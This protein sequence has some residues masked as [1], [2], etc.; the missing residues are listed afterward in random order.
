MTPRTPGHARWILPLLLTFFLLA[1]GAFRASLPFQIATW[2][3][4][5]L[6]AA[7]VVSV[8]KR[9]R[10][11][12]RHRQELAAAEAAR[13]EHA[14]RVAA[15]LRR[16]LPD[17]APRNTVQVWDLVPHADEV[18]ITDAPVH[19][20][21]YYGQTVNYTTSSGAFFG[22][23]MFVAAG[24]VGTA[25]GNASARSRAEAMAREQWREHRTVRLVVTNQRLCCMVGQTWLSFY[26]STITA[27]YPSAGHRS[28]V[29]T[30]GD[31]QPLL[32]AGPWAPAAAVVATLMTLGTDALVNHPG[33]RPLNGAPGLEPKPRDTHRLPPSDT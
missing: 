24:L 7:G 18:F 23:P 20:A 22:S 8:V 4:A 33:L 3:A 27:V 14:W 5:A 11:V 10:L 15:Q 6:T 9:T 32:I 16:D 12:A 13:N 28:L 30:F 17:R 19:Y 31:S 2:G 25:V 29:C 1:G 21:R 26:Y